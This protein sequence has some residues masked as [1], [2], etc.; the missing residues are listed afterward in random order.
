MD[1]FVSTVK[2]I[3]TACAALGI[4]P[5]EFH[6]APSAFLTPQEAAARIGIS[7]KA[8]S[9]LSHEG[10]L[11]SYRPTRRTVRF[12]AEDVERVH[13]IVQGARA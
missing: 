3:Q 13:R 11:P 12:S 9:P 1:A 10:F 6:F 2:A 4:D 5:D 7:R 8:V